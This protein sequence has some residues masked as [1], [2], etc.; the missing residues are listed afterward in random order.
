MCFARAE[1][2]LARL[3]DALVVGP[4]A[5]A[6]FEATGAIMS[7]TLP[8]EK[9]TDGHGCWLALGHRDIDDISIQTLN[10]IKL[11]PASA[12]AVLRARPA[13]RSAGAARRGPPGCL[14]AEV[15]YLEIERDPNY[16]ERRFG[17]YAG[18]TGGSS[19]L[20]GRVSCRY[21]RLIECAD[22]NQ[23]SGHTERP[24]KPIHV[25]QKLIAYVGYVSVDPLGDIAHGVG[26]E[27]Y[28]TPCQQI[29]NHGERINFSRSSFD[30]ARFVVYAWVDERLLSSRRDIARRLVETD[31]AIS[32]FRDLRA[33]A[34]FH[35]AA[36]LSAVICRSR[37]AAM[38]SIRFREPTRKGYPI[39]KNIGWLTFT[40]A[41]SAWFGGV[42]MTTRRPS[43]EQSL[44][45][46]FE[47]QFPGSVRVGRLFPETY[48]DIPPAAPQGGTL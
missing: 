1:A 32:V 45:R 28:R 31:V 36:L 35:A 33:G 20:V 8:V 9:M 27:R 6:P 37:H 44:P 15:Y 34:S 2:L 39:M 25:F 13:G 40:P 12:M 47:R 16:G 24:M 46:R 23:N 3:L 10:A 17:G 7:A 38:S 48:D 21:D 41:V 42:T 4:Q 30:A 14:G 22:H 11:G 18:L 43:A 5:I 26:R 29:E 19:G